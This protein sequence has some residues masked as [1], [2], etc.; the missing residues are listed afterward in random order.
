MQTQ[1]DQT[2]NRSLAGSDTDTIRVKG[3]PFGR[4]NGQ[5]KYSDEISSWSGGTDGT[6]KVVCRTC[7]IDKT[8][9]T[10]T[11]SHFPDSQRIR[12]KWG[13]VRSQ[14]DSG[15]PS[16]GGRAARR[17]QRGAVQH[18]GLHARGGAALVATTVKA[19]SRLSGKPLNGLVPPARDSDRKWV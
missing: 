18:P 12:A 14:A 11:S 6:N 4:L 3:L 1:A 16:A 13:G 2:F 7:S 8:C 5:E 19:V 17:W 9:P 15:E 10:P